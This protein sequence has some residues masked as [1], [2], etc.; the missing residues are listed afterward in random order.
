MN[1]KSFFKKNGYLY[2]PSLFSDNEVNYFLD[3][4]NYLHKNSN[5][6]FTQLHNDKKTWPLI[7]NQKIIDVL[8]EITGEKI[9]YLYHSTSISQSKD[10]KFDNNWHRDSTCRNFGIGGD[11]ADDYNV[12]R[13][14]V[15]LDKGSKSGL[16]IIKKSH[17]SKGY[18]CKLLNFLRNKLKR[19]YYKKIF[20]YFFDNLIGKKIFTKPGDCVFFY[21]T[22]YHSALKNDYKDKVYDRKAFF[23]S[24]GTENQHSKNFMNYYLFHRGGPSEE[25]NFNIDEKIKDELFKNLE[26]KEIEIEPPKEK[27]D[28]VGATN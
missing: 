19:L 16:N 6:Q 8:K 3:L 4:N 22:T 14:A 7:T 18:I 27:I 15:Y 28:I 2:C 13:V 20:R 12:I 10:S 9:C 21:A 26:S 1:K 23:L 17:N 11:W 5:K 24:Y 25:H